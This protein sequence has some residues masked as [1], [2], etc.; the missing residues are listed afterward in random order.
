MEQHDI[1]IARVR[2]AYREAH[3]RLIERLRS[4]APDV[5]VRT[6]PGG[7]WSV[8]QIGW[9]VAA[10]DAAFAGLMSG[11]RPSELLPDGF[12]TREWSDIVANIPAK[13]EA[14]GSVVPP[15]A[16]TLEEALAA[17]DVSAMKME[18]ALSALSSA[19]GS[20]YG[21]THRIVGTIT[22]YQV[23]EWAIAHTIRHNAQAKRLLGAHGASGG[24][25]PT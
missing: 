6:P 20:R 9:H 4:V 22:L 5:A 12:H 21:I 8:A 24:R 10:V 14:S 16:V 25:S 19:R 7:G 2:D 13:L 15:A 3:G 1:R 17:L 11:E 18:A 23:G